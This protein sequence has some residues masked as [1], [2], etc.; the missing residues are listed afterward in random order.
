MERIRFAAID[1]KNRKKIRFSRYELW[2][3]SSR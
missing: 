3:Q 1:D 2:R